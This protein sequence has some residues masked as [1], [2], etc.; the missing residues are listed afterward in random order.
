MN[1]DGLKVGGWPSWVQNAEWP[2]TDGGARMMFV[3]QLDYSLSPNVLW[4]GGGY[5]YLFVSPPGGGPR[6]AEL[7][8]LTT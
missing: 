1:V 8:I 6:K 2:Q 4:G 3:A 7:S 5:A